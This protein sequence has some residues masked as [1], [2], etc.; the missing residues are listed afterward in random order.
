MK[1]IV[2]SIGITA[3]FRDFVEA[4][5]QEYQSY[6]DMID[7][8][9]TN[10]KYDDD[11]GV[12]NSVAFKEFFNDYREKKIEYDTTMHIIQRDYIPEKFK[13]DEYSFDVN[14]DELKIDIYAREM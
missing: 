7:T 4:R 13:K 10:H 12:I 5:Y 11:A 3:E 1:N 6:K 14:F 8:V 9:F 2:K